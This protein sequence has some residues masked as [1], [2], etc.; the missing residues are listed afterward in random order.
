MGVQSFRPQQQQPMAVPVQSTLY[1]DMSRP[2]MSRMEETKFIGI[3]PEQQNI[4]FEL[5]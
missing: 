5:A 2:Q 1:R 4:T 3:A